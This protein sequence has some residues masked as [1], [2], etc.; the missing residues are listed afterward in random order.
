M[1]S[2]HQLEKIGWDIDRHPKLDQTDPHT[3][4]NKPVNYQQGYVNYITSAHEAIRRSGKPN[5]RGCKIPV[6]SNL[7][8]SFLENELVDYHDKEIL[9]HRGGYSK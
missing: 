1:D 3:H 5:F 2:L 6:R 8:I 4:N 7:N 9:T